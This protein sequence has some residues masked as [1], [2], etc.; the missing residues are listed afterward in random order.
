MG[1]SLEDLASLS[2]YI[3]QVIGILGAFPD[4]A[5]HTTLSIDSFGLSLSTQYGIAF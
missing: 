5:T 2:E 1:K 3:F 4:F